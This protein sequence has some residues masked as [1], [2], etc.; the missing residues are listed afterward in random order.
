MK[1]EGT[2]PLI[3]V[4]FFFFPIRSR[5]LLHTNST[6][7]CVHM[8]RYVAGR[9]QVKAN[10]CGRFGTAAAGR[11]LQLGLSCGG[12][13]HLPDLREVRELRCLPASAVC[14][15]GGRGRTLT[16]PRHFPRIALSTA[17]GSVFTY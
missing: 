15:R 5:D 14:A 9:A 12:E 2:S 8:P 1:W 11:E 17:I 3:E 6:L 7:C 16:S 10:V 13:V 4:V